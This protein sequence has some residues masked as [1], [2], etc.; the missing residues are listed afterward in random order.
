MPFDLEFWNIILYHNSHRFKDNIFNRS[1]SQN[2]IFSMNLNII[3]HMM[4]AAA[5]EPQQVNWS[6]LISCI[7]TEVY[8]YLMVVMNDMLFAFNLYLLKEVIIMAF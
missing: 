3:D 8:A 4:F 6:F 2:I 1:L 7:I 5:I